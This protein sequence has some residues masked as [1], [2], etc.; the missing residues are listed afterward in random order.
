MHLLKQEALSAFLDFCGTHILIAHNAPFDMAFIRAAARRSGLNREF[1][2]LDTVPLCRNLLPEL[3]K[4]K[5]NI[6][7]EHLKLGE[8]N[9][10]R[11][12]DDAICWLLFS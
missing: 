6:V 3:K 1:T 7:A 2:S 12:C 9:H 4:H 10:H 8:F 5:L 11:A